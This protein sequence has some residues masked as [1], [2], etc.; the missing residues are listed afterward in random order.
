MNL[1]GK[2]LS[3]HLKS[4]MQYKVSFFLTAF[5]Q[6]LISFSAILGVYF[7]LDRFHA[8]KGYTFTD[9]LLCSSVII[10]AFSLAECFARGFDQ[11]PKAISNGEF[12]RM[13]V[14]PRSAIFQILASKLEL[15]RIGRMLQAIL[16]MLVAFAKSDIHWSPSKVLTILLMIVG[17]TVVFSCLFLLYAAFSFFYAGGAGIYERPDG[18]RQGIRAV[19][20]GCLWESRFNLLHR[21]CHLRLVSAD[22]AGLSD[23]EFGEYPADVCASGVLC[24]PPP[25]LCNLEIWSAALPVNRL[26]KGLYKH[27]SKMPSENLA[28]HFALVLTDFIG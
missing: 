6:F 2:Y 11:F 21:R 9:I 23:R 13:L 24:L 10:M 18:W 26:L 28:R 1:Y 16:M 5:G 8:I 3:I 17:G 4:L 15:S 7:L 22:S 27:K 25:L 14:R 20:A 12:D 19:S